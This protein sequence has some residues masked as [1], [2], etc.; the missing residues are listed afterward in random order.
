[1]KKERKKS[2]ERKENISRGRSV[3]SSYTFKE[4]YPYTV[5]IALVLSRI[6]ERITEGLS[7]SK[8]RHL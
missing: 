1:M 6:E 8:A 3:S 7:K 5:H 2:R 4:D